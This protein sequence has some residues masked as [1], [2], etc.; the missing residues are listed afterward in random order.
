M[1]WNDY[2][3]KMRGSGM[4]MISRIRPFIEKIK[5]NTMSS[6]TSE[7]LVF[8]DNE[9]EKRNRVFGDNKREKRTWVFLDDELI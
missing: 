6:K 5:R 3:Q 9:W 1:N 8:S 7:S 4:P 2:Q